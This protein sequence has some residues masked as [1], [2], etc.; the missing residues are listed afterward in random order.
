MGNGRGLAEERLV[1]VGK[2][3]QFVLGDRTAKGPAERVIAKSRTVNVVQV[4]GPAIGTQSAPAH[5]FIKGAVEGIGAGLDGNVHHPAQVIAE[6]GRR[7]A[8][9]QVEFLHRI[10]RGHKTDVIVV[11]LVVVHAVKNEVVF[12]LAGAVYI[13]RSEERRV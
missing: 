10:G 9:D 1:I 8:G 11:R 2:E 4:V 7:I 13:G 3:E 5:V 12:L 6:I